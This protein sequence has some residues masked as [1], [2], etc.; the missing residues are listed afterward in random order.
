MNNHPDPESGS[1]R[2]DS[3]DAAQHRQAA[4]GDMIDRRRHTLKLLRNAAIAGPVILT[5]KST[6][7]R[8]ASASHI[9][10][11]GTT[12]TQSDN[13]DNDNQY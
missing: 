6:P 11:G 12:G 10:T 5:L 7:A 4:A 2:P 1:S 9:S 3:G 8:A 13:E